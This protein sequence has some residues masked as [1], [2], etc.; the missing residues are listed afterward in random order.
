MEPRRPSPG[1]E[2]NS[3]FLYTIGRQYRVSAWPIHRSSGRELAAGSPSAK[4]SCAGGGEKGERMW[5]GGS[6]LGEKIAAVASAR[7]A[8]EA[9]LR[10]RDCN[11]RPKGSS[12]GHEL[13]LGSTAR[14]SSLSR[15]VRVTRPKIEAK[16]E[17]GEAAGDDGAKR[18]RRP[19]STG[20]AATRKTPASRL[21]GAA[22][23]RAAPRSPTPL[24]TPHPIRRKV[25]PPL[26]RDFD[27]PHLV[28]T[29]A[30]LAAFSFSSLSL[31]TGARSRVPA[32]PLALAR[33]R[34][35]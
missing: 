2:S 3:R 7:V 11:A 18:R 17:E 34:D 6:E 27:R 22:P 16:R 25:S 12:A 8:I 4:R 10:R 35:V 15:G 13:K 33:R 14:L 32:A 29:L 24:I 26:R 1:A 20:Q 9:Q 21:R 30:P 28:T 5:G 19:P 31:S 23:R